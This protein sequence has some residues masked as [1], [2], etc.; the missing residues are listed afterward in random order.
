MGINR[1][2]YVGP[3]IKVP[4]ALKDDENFNV[5]CSSGCGNEGLTMHMRFCSHCGA[6]VKRVPKGQ[7][8][9]QALMPSDVDHGDADNFWRP[10]SCE[11]GPGKPWSI[12]LPHYVAASGTLEENSNDICV[13]LE[14]VDMAAELKNFEAGVAPMLHALQH[15]MCVT[16][17]LQFGVVAYWS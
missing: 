6:A 10:E 3:F 14:G 17:T 4:H 13:T 16:P 9:L 7:P 15:T 12:W 11:S 2:V 8:Y 5:V 1:Y